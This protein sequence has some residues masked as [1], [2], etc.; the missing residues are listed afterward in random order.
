MKFFNPYN[1]R[2]VI[3]KEL[4]T[5]CASRLPR[6][7]VFLSKTSSNLAANK[8]QLRKVIIAKNYASSRETFE[9]DS[10]ALLLFRNQ[11]SWRFDCQ[12]FCVK[13]IDGARNSI[14]TKIPPINVGQQISHELNYFS[15]KSCFER[16]FV[17]LFFL[18]AK[19]SQTTSP[20]WMAAPL[21][22]AKSV[23]A[24]QT[25]P[26]H[27]MS[28]WGFARRLFVKR[29][30][31]NVITVRALVDKSFAMERSTVW[32]DRMSLIVEGRTSV[33]SEF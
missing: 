16:W 32:M 21:R 23:M 10:I 18:R 28:G 22:L 30:S 15:A 12:F 2:L 7:L 31:L 1:L 5:V 14:P 3:I 6:S 27:P 4:E 8:A 25:V 29:I 26:T 24:S 33:A 11:P 20:A 9:N 19:H 13:T 17:F